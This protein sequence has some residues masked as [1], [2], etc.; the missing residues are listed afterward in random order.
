MQNRTQRGLHYFICHEASSALQ[1]AV[2]RCEEEAIQWGLENF[3]TGKSWR[4]NVMKRMLVIC[5]EDI[6]PANLSLILLIEDILDLIL[7]ESK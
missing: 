1:K 3:W 5:S 6:G 7:S 4:T 2:R